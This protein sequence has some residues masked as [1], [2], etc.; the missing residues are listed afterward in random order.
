[1]DDLELMKKLATGKVICDVP[2]ED[3]R[4]VQINYLGQDKWV[5]AHL[6]RRSVIILSDLEVA[7]LKTILAQ[8]EEKVVIDRKVLAFLNKAC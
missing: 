8:A 2:E 5:A 6:R 4:V 7:E 3:A 1:M